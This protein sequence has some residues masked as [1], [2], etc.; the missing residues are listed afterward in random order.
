MLTHS[1]LTLTNKLYRAKQLHL[2]FSLH[3]D[4]PPYLSFQ[5]AKRY[6][7]LLRLFTNVAKQSGRKFR[8]LS[9][10]AGHQ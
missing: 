6:L 3:R 9:C 7:C 2:L 10:F 5:W 4:Y 8:D 1:L